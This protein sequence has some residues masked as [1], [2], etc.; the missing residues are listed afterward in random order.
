MIFSINYILIFYNGIDQVSILSFFWRVTKPH[1]FESFDIILCISRALENFRLA[2]T[3]G[4][5]VDIKI[6]SGTFP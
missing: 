2:I 4:V 6:K 1:G 5:E 3:I